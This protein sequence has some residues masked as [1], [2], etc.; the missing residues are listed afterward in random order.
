MKKNFNEIFI[1]KVQKRGYGKKK[2]IIDFAFK[3][4]E[5]IESLIRSIPEDYDD[6]IGEFWKDIMIQRVKS[7]KYSAICYKEHLEK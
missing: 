5:R 2:G 4:I 1:F 7:L 3:E 6:F